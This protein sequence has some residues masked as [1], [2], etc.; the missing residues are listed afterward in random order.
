MFRHWIEGKQIPYA[1]IQ[2]KRISLPHDLNAPPGGCMS[3]Q[4]FRP[5]VCPIEYIPLFGCGVLEITVQLCMH[6]I[7]AFT[8]AVMMIFTDHQL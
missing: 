1:N 7:A 3:R 6:V 4:L 2:E 5:V 8:L